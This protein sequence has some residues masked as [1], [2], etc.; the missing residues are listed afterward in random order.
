[1]LSGA[2][3]LHFSPGRESFAGGVLLAGGLLAVICSLLVAAFARPRPASADKAGVRD[4]YVRYFSDPRA[5]EY[6]GE[7]WKVY[8]YGGEDTRPWTTLRAIHDMK[9]LLVLS[10]ETTPYWLPK[11]AL[12]RE[13][14]LD[15]LRS[16]AKAAL[17][18]RELLFTV[19]ALA[20]APVYACAMLAH[21]LRLSVRT[22]LLAYVVVVMFVYFFGFSRP[23]SPQ[24]GPIWLLLLVPAILLF[25]EF[26]YYVQRYYQG[27]KRKA[28]LMAAVMT[29]C[30]GYENDTVRWITEYRCFTEIREIPGAFLLYVNPQTFHL[31]P[32]K[33][34]SAGQIQQFREL[35]TSN[36]AQM[37][38][39]GT[40]AK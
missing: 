25:A 10:T 27:Y 32:K 16:L 6:D 2:L 37:Q 28:S 21:N 13:G 9:T 23:D 30:I 20:S 38:A 35:L 31:I 24:A 11:D 40:S 14:H 12:E 29:N 33:G 39:R 5:L 34:F 15:S 17:N 22:R 18:K 26:L 7:G 8:W 4:Q 19:P 3:W 36:L 1:M